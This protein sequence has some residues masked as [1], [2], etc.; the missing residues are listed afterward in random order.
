MINRP[1]GKPRQAYAQLLAN[2]HSQSGGP[3]PGPTLR[4]GGNS[5]EESCYAATGIPPPNSSHCTHKITAQDLSAYRRFAEIAPNI[6]YV[7]DTNL[8]QGDAAVGAAHVSAVGAAGLWPYIQA[9]EIGNECDHWP[10][11]DQLKFADYEQRFAAFAEAYKAA[12]MPPK[13][14]QGATFCCLNPA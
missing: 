13:F 5:A 1:D 3:H 12:G 4:F 10:P 11:S 14:I 7:I 8:M 9:V 2:L 6:S